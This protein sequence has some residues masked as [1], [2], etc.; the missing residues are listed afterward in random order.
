[1]VMKC[2]IISGS[3]LTINDGWSLKM[4]HN[5]FLSS[6]MGLDCVGR[7]KWRHTITT[8]TKTKKGMILT[9]QQVFWFFWENNGL[10]NRSRLSSRGRS[11]IDDDF[12]CKNTKASHRARS[13]W[14]I[15]RQ[16]S[17]RAE[18]SILYHN[19]L[20]H[21]CAMDNAKHSL[22]N[23]NVLAFKQQDHW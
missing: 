21:I 4:R 2:G 19:E 13:R 22:L 11:L 7:R 15:A 6:G 20:C 10:V 3:C 16:I 8:H 23:R 14:L 17:R 5:T 18:C 1:M 9:N 12:R